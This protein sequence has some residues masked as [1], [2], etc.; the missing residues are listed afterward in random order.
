MKHGKNWWK[1]VVDAMGDAMT[2]KMLNDVLKT[3]RRNIPVVLNGLYVAVPRSVM[4][5]YLR[6]AVDDAA[7]RAGFR[8][9]NETIDAG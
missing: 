5:D 9:V 8:R 3:R 6:R 7:F 4:R 1:D 2:R